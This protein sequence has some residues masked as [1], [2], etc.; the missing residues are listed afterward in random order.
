MTCLTPSVLVIALEL[1][2]GIMVWSTVSGEMNIPTLS[3][4]SEVDQDALLVAHGIHP[5]AVPLGDIQAIS[6]ERVLDLA[7]EYPN[8]LFTCVGGPPCTDVSL[9]KEGRAGAFGQFSGLREEFKR[10]AQPLRQK[11]QNRFVGLMECTAME[12]HDRLTLVLPL[13][14]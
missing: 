4:F 2:A 3:F 10:I 13:T 14:T 7:M 12:E 11:L 1:F 8:A 6:V 9:L 5:E